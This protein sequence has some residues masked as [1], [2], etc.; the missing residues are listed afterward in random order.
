MFQGIGTAIMTP[1]TEEMEVNYQDLR[2][3]ARM[4]VEAGTDSIVVLGTT[5]ET[6]TITLDE[7][8]QIVK[9]I[10]EE[11]KGKIPVIVGTGTNSAVDVLKSNKMAEE[12]AADGLLIVTPYYNKS[13]QEG[14]YQSF[15]LYANQTKLPIIL[16]NVPSRTGVNLEIDTILRLHDEC[17]NIIGV[18]EAG[19]NISFAAELIARRPGTLKVYSGNDDQTIPMMALGAEGLIS[20][21]GNIIPEDMVNLT[22]LMLQG[23]IR[24]AQ[25]FNNRLNKL[26]NDLFIEVNPIPVKFA[27]SLMGICDNSV[28]LP[29]IPLSEKNEKILEQTMQD[30]ELI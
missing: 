12:A 29:L 8:K 4:Q 26:F 28:R 16:Y 24:E 22:H 27:A 5:G 20:V 25:K 1:F 21:A 3:I 6:P 10:V 11:I 13:S 23:N 9:T 15:K 18:K 14:L 19:G 7:R 2:N 30:L 17:E